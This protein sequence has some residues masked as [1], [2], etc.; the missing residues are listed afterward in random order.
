MDNDSHE[1]DKYSLANKKFG[2]FF[3]EGLNLF[4]KN[5]GKII[6]PFI[7]F[8]VISNLMIVFLLTD[9]RWLANTFTLS[10]DS[11][12]D[13]MLTA[14]DTVTEG[15]MILV[16]QSMLVEIGISGLA[17]I[18]GA[19]FTVIAMSSVGK[20]LHK[21]YLYG[22][23]DFGEE[24][25]KAFNKKMILPIIILGLCVPT[26][27]FFMLFIPGI[28]IFYY[29]IFLV[30]TYNN[31]DIKNPTKETR[32]IVKGNFWNIVGLFL[33]SFIITTLV[34]TPIDYVLTLAWN[35]DA[36]TYSAWLDPATRNYPL[37]IL[38]QLSNDIIGM[39]LS[40]LFICMM[41]PLFVTSKARYDLGYRRGYYP[42]RI[43]YGGEQVPYS[44]YPRGSESS[45]SF[46]EVE[47]V[48]KVSEVKEGMYCPF[49]GTYIKTPKKFCVKC[50]ESLEFN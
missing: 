19:L 26:G 35:V 13:K 9:L 5:Y 43:S 6:I 36:A 50:G 27:T 18:I 2:D 7:I 38:Y 12:L 32:M 39:V 20:Y 25:K 14:P 29:Y 31:K 1:I 15:E 10:L 30:Y 3:S 28:V 11:I 45:S 17:G 47:L 40:P 44:S 37:L 22:N 41:T 4:G 21:K 46:D 49:C 24:F 8:L 34:S 16:L 48:A 33:A 23:A 42:Q